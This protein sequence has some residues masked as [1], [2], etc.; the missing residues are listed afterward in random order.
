MPICLLLRKVLFRHHTRGWMTFS[1]LDFFST[2]QPK[3]ATVGIDFGCKNS[4]VAIV[5]SLVPEVVPSETGCSIPSYVTPIDPKDSDGYG[6]ALQQLDRLGKC[7]AVGELAKRRLSRQ[8]S[9]VVFNIKKL[10]G[11]QF[12]DHNVQEMRKRVHFSIVEGERG[13]AWVEIC[14]MKFSPVEIASVIFAR[15]KDIILMHQF[16]H[17]FK[18]VIS[19]PIFFN[20][21]QRKEIMLAGHKAGLEILQIIDEPIAAALSST[22][23]KEGTIVVFD[24]GAG[25]Y[26]VSILGVSGTKIEIK[27]QFGNP[28]V[29]GDQFDDILL[30]YSV[31]QIRKFYSVDVCG[32]KYGMMLLAEA[33]EQAKVALSSQHEVTVSLPFIISSAKCPGDP[34]ISISR[35]EFENLGVNLVKQIRDKC[36]TLLA[37]ANISSNDID[38]VI[39]TGG[40]TRVPMI[41]K[42]IFDVFGKHQATKVNHEEAVVIGSAIQACLIVEHQRQISE[43]IIPLSIGIESEGIFVRV[44][45]RHS[46]IPTKKTVKIPAWRGYGESL[47]INVY[48]GEHVLVQHNVFLG[49]VELI[50]NQ[51][52]CQ[53]SIYFELTFEVDKDY[54][55][56][57]GGRNFGDQHEAAYDLVK[58]LK[59]F[60]VREIVMCK[61]SV[62]KAVKSALLDWTMH[63][64]DFRA[65]LIRQATYIVSTLSDVLSARKDEVPKDLFEEAAKS[66]TNL[67]MTLDG[68]AH[69]LNEKMLA[70][71]SAKLKVLQWMPPSESPCR[72]YSDYED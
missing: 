8:P 24:M 47:P 25:S 16:H 7:V 12:D 40:M 23:I 6:W 33:V 20:Q 50:N 44:I 68:D 38:E 52:S 66:L 10:A 59:V 3:V 49:V 63:G 48:L 34:N 1:F 39:L 60:P 14:R 53:G 22:T 54:V 65:R 35:A 17:E 30:D 5:D 43:D 45:P 26:N 9:D 11:K 71:E 32:D 29:G 2:V 4:R 31:A 61:Q 27:T 56:K 19:V 13:E 58:P 36:Q 21:Q 41:Q 57:V 42:I 46:T 67:L 64:I 15:L 70:A 72:D 28:C 18:V 69:V 62:D 55:V 37:E 51:R